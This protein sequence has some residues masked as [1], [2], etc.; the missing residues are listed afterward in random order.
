MAVGDE[1]VLLKDT[2]DHVPEITTGTA[3][4][5]AAPGKIG[6][7]YIDTVNK[8]VYIA[9]GST[10]AGDFELMNGP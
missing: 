4:P 6:D 3:A 1:H 7:I 10:D 2:D 5:S 9:V 8:N